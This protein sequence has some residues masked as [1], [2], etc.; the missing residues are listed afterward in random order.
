LLRGAQPAASTAKAPARHHA[1]AEAGGV[2]LEAAVPGRHAAHQL[3][4]ATGDALTAGSVEVLLIVSPDSGD[5]VQL[6]GTPQGVRGQRMRAILRLRGH[7][8]CSAGGEAG[9]PGSLASRAARRASFSSFL[10]AVLTCSDAASTV[11]NTVLKQLKTRLLF[12][13]SC[14]LSP[15]L[16]ISAL[17][18]KQQS[19]KERT[20]FPEVCISALCLKR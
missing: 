13:G 20:L 14:A 8:C 17:R 11:R 15:H 10:R 1:G 16:V 9:A 2:R 3:R 4:A 19:R 5:D 6:G 18:R 12:S 7:A